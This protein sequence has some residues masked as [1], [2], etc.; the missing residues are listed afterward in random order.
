[1]VLTP[2]LVRPSS[3][4]P[5]I[6]DAASIATRYVALWNETDPDRRKALMTD[7]WSEVG[8]YRDP[9]MQGDGRSEVCVPQPL[10]SQACG[11]QR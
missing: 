9:P 3:R 1:M 10:K 2:E 8:T 7:L 4:R 5:P 6:T 11:S